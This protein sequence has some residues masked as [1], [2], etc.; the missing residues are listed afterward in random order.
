MGQAFSGVG[1]ASWE[2]SMSVK[3]LL[4]PPRGGLE[5]T[6]HVHLNRLLSPC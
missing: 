5:G 4:L 6:G 3:C 1:A 2:E